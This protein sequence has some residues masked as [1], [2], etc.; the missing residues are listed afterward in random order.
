VSKATIVCVLGMHRSGTSLLAR[1]LN[2]LGVDLGPQEHLM[3]PS[4]ANPAGHWESLPIVDIN[5]EILDRF[6]GTWSEPPELP[7]GWERRA[8]LADLRQRARE[9][10]EADFS[11][12]ELWGFKDP[13]TCLT[14]PFW[15]RVVPPMRYVIAFRNPL[16][17]AS[18]LE[19]RMR[20]PIP[21]KQGTALWLT[22]VR[23]ALAATAG[24][25]RRLVF[26]E[27]L[28][29]GSDALVTELARFV[30]LDEPDSVD[31]LPHDAAQVAVSE[32]LWHHRTPAPNVMDATEL[33]FHVKALYLGLRLSVPG[34]EDIGDEVLDL[35]AGYAGDA[36]RELAELRSRGSEVDALR[37]QLRYLE[38]SRMS[39]DRR[40]SE[41]RLELQRVSSAR[42]EEVAR[43][44]QLQAE[45]DELRAELTRREDDERGE[46]PVAASAP[47]DR[48]PTMNGHDQDLISDVRKRA[49]Q[50]IPAEA[51]V[52][53]ASKGDDALLQL[54]GRAAWH[55]PMAAD[56]QYLGYHPAGD[57]AAIAQLEALRARGADH[58]V[59]PST[60]HWWLEHYQGFSR[61]LADHYSSLLEDERCAI[62]E[63]RPRGGDDDGD[64]IAAL[65]RAVAGLRVRS[66]RDPSVLD[67]DSG[68]GIAERF[69]ELPVF[70]PSDDADGLPYLD[71]TA[72]VVVLASTDAPRM[73]EARRVAAEAVIT[74]DPD[75]SGR[76]ALEWS[77]AG[78]DGW[79]EDLNVTL[80]TDGSSGWPATARAVAESLDEGFAGG[81]TVLGDRESVAAASAGSSRVGSRPSE[82]VVAGGSK[83]ADRAR[84]AV[85]ATDHAI[86]TFVT[87]PGVPLPGW[88]ISIAEIFSS[89]RDAGLVGTRIVTPDGVLEEA[90]GILG[91]DGSRQRRGQGDHDPD[92]PHYRFL[93]RVDFCS[94]PLLAT[95]RDVFNRLGGLSQVHGARDSLVE[96]SLRA[97]RN[98]VPVYYQPEARI[99]ALQ[100]GSP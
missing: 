78:R 98:G 95:R 96:F 16:D 55:F 36:E 3:R 21:S 7:P 40:L 59:L 100:N 10:I 80:L 84:T 76:A 73:E 68:L 79:G 6:G 18:S 52:L 74:A 97:G 63:L 8:E 51:T 38:E 47:D 70:S 32:G 69:P 67:W 45:L 37:Q 60:A 15:Q 88:L 49:D 42:D 64:A 83:L 71:G 9:V 93:R 19:A 28:M 46:V 94:P 27:D 43:R 29:G 53:V 44:Q 30:G 2:L 58:L 99:V 24:H 1:M 13:R 66:G 82:V 62:F 14:A 33:A 75:R 31:P 85:E 23:S 56:G 39:L 72:D 41:G 91:P 5:D 86:Q 65:K 12:A 90:G 35:L 4:S 87:A 17:V 61:H 25:P 50:I 81:F 92:R 54:D 34:A 22:Y 48:D 20:E 77:A 11:G 89:R 26:Y 57:T